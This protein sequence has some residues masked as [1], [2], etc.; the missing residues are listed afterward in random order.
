MKK[1]IISL[2]IA[3]L[4]LVSMTAFAGGEKE[5][6]PA[7]KVTKEK[8]TVGFSLWTMEY[9]F[10]QNVEKGVRDACADL[11]Y[12]YI[13]IDQNADPTKMVQDINTLVGQGVDGIVITPVDPGAIGPAVQNA[14]DAGIPVVCADIGMT[15]PVNALLISNNY[16]GGQLAMEFIDKQ[17]KEMGLSGRKVG[18]GRVK[19]QWTYARGRGQGFMDKAK[20]LG[21]EV[22]AELVVENPSAEGGYDIMQQIFS[23]APDVVGVFFS[24]GREA[25]GA[26]NAIKAAGEDTIVVGYNG[27]PEEL[28]AIEDGVLDATVAQQPYFIGYESVKV[29]KELMDGEADYEKAEIPVEVELLT[30][31][32][33]KE[34]A[35]KAEERRGQPAY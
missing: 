1:K 9:T 21:Y 35:A 34:W 14:R 23:K 5:K 15:G 26:A 12:E 8:M 30:P 16:E 25:V 28:Q 11:G 29:L 33:Y 19:P 17:V 4:V 22:A 2:V 10:F 27:D 18:A 7:E 13:M 32:N 3:L 31:D 24:S 6:A 20:E